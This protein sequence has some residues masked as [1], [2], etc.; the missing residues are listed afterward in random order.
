[1]LLQQG[2]SSGCSYDNDT[3]L[4][5]LWHL[6]RRRRHC[7]TKI[8]GLTGA[9]VERSL[10]LRVY[11]GV[12]PSP[13]YFLGSSESEIFLFILPHPSLIILLC[14]ALHFQPILTTRLHKRLH[15]EEDYLEKILHV[16]VA[17]AVGGN[18]CLSE[19]RCLGGLES[20]T[21][22]KVDDG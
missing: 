4:L 5:L 19:L 3:F 9:L 14:C 1:M 12:H 15:H 16:V 7:Q 21:E 22:E 13:P 10:K 20:S 11:F 8:L 18:N 2:R 6:Q 17:E